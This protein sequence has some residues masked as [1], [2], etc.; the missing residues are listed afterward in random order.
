MPNADAERLF[1]LYMPLMYAE[2]VR[3]GIANEMDRYFTGS[4][5]MF[6]ESD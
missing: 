1:R 6:T 2:Y 4:G 5:G 3:I